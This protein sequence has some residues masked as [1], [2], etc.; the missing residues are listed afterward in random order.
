MNCSALLYHLGSSY[1][2][3]RAAQT[4]IISLFKQFLHLSLSYKTVTETVKLNRGL[5]WRRI[6]I[7][8]AIKSYFQSI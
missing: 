1:N 2:E 6:V 4:T 3:I 8:I 5:W 7:G